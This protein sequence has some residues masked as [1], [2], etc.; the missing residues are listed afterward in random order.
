MFNKVHALLRNID[1]YS[2]QTK[3]VLKV[4]EFCLNTRVKIYKNIQ[5]VLINISDTKCT[6]TVINLSYTVYEYCMKIIIFEFSI[7]Y[8]YKSNAIF[9]IGDG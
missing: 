6:V 7:E 9:G 4:V 1:I 3:Y 5:S 8:I 2:K